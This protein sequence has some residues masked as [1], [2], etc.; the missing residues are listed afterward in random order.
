MRC[1]LLPHPQLETIYRDSLASLHLMRE[2]TRQKRDAGL[3]CIFFLV[4]IAKALICTWYKPGGVLLLLV[5][6]LHY[7]SN[8][9]KPISLPSFMSKHR[10]NF[11]CTFDDR[12]GLRLIGVSYQVQNWLI[13]WFFFSLANNGPSWTVCWFTSHFQLKRWVFKNVNVVTKTFN[14]WVYFTRRPDS[15]T[16][17]LFDQTARLFQ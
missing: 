4:S 3:M 15:K 1:S 5:I 6:S 8:P 16:L 10:L 2:E 13:L 12:S 11:K 9:Q 14:I 7:I 17:I